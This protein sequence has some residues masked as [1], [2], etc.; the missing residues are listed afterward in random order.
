MC[1]GEESGISPEDMESLW[2]H[3]CL[4]PPCSHIPNT[5]LGTIA[6]QRK[7]EQRQHKA[8]GIA[9]H[10]PW[11]GAHCLYHCAPMLH[12]TET[13]HVFKRQAVSSAIQSS[14]MPLLKPGRTCYGL[15]IPTTQTGSWNLGSCLCPKLWKEP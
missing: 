2:I 5:S 10:S 1:P 4:K 3:R 11:E 6:T 14:P 15:L 7:M 9:V 8:L 13:C 12:F